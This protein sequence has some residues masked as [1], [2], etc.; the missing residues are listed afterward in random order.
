MTASSGDHSVVASYAGDASYA[1]STSAPFNYSVQAHKVVF[2][3]SPFAIL[4]TPGDG[5]YGYGCWPGNQCSAYAGDSLP[6]VVSLGGDVCTFATGTVTLALGTQTQTVTMTPVGYPT[7]QLLIG[8]ASFTNLQPGTYQLTGSYSGDSNFA[9]ASS[10]PYTVTVAAGPN[11]VPATTTTVSVTPSQISYENGS[12]TFDITVTG[13]NGPP[14]GYVYIYGDGTYNIWDILL[15]PSG[16]N[17][18]TASAEIHQNEYNNLFDT[19]TPYLGIV[20]IVATYLGSSS[21]QGS[22][23]APV[24]LDVVPTTVSPDFLLAPQAG[25]VTVQAGSSTT[26]AINL[27]SVNEFNGAM[28]LA[29]TPS[30]SQITCSINP[31]SATLFG[32]ATAT[33]TIKAAAKT[34]GLARPMQ[35][36]QSQWPAAAGFLGI[37]VFFAGGRARRAFRNRVLLGLALLAVL[38]VASCG[39]KSSGSAG[40]GSG[41][42]GGVTTASAYSVVVSGTG[43]GIVHNA[44]ITVLV[45]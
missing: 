42:G 33:L 35:E 19:F 22:V 27:A 31:T 8:Y 12:A 5:P 9:A 2:G 23:S 13:S 41:G 43:N 25:Q 32:E 34:T 21:Y 17:T 7:G 10:G 6:V 14:A 44:K 4:P 16:P 37:F 29:C 40:G 11:P 30:S 20:P 3:I 1:A 39:G 15:T 36:R 26:L 18:S 45:P 38:S 24:P 28:A